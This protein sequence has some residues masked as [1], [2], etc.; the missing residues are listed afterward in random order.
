MKYRLQ[1]VKGYDARTPIFYTSGELSDYVLD[2]LT[3][4]LSI[5]RSVQYR[6][7]VYQAKADFFRIG[8]ITLRLDAS[9]LRWIPLVGWMQS[10]RD[11]ILTVTT[12]NDHILWKG[13]ATEVKTTPDAGAEW[14][15]TN[16]YN[17][18]DDVQI[19]GDD[20][21][22]RSAIPAQDIIDEVRDQLPIFPVVDA[23]TWF[24]VYRP[25]ENTSARD[26]LANMLAA[27]GRIL[28][29]DGN[30]DLEVRAIE[31][32]TA[33][34]LTSGLTITHEDLISVRI[35]DD[36]KYMY[37]TIRYE[38]FGVED[39]KIYQGELESY[40]YPGNFLFRYGRR[41]IDMDF[42]HLSV[43]NADFVAEQWQARLILPK[44]RALIEL[45]D[46]NRQ[47]L[48]LERIKLELDHVANVPIPIWG[49][50]AVTSI[51]INLDKDTIE[52]EAEEI[53]P[54]APALVTTFAPVFA[55]GMGDDQDWIEDSSSVGLQVPKASGL[56][57]PTYSASGLPA[58]ISFN[59]N[60]RLISG[61]PTS[62]GSGTITITAS[63]SQG[64]DTWTVDYAIVS[65][66]N[67][68][69]IALPASIYDEQSDY[70]VWLPVPGN[71]PQIDTVLT[72][73][74]NTTRY[75][76]SFRLY[77]SGRV[78][79][80]L[81]PTQTG[82]GGSGADFSSAVELNG[83]FDITVG[84]NDLSVN[85][86]GADVADIYDFT[87]SNS[88]E[89]TAF[90]N[91]VRALSGNQSATLVLRDYTTG[92]VVL[93]A[94]NFADDTGDDAD[95]T[96]NS[97][98]TNIQVPPASGTPIPTYTA[99]GLPA[100]ITFNTSSRVISGTPTAT[101]SG[102]IT[103][104]ATN[105]EGTDTWTVAY[106]TSVTLTAP[107]WTDDTGDDVDWTQNSAITDI[108]VPAASGNPTPTYAASGLPAGVTF[109]TG[110]R[111]I[112]GTPTGSGSGT[113]TITASNSE[114]SDTWTVDYTTSGALTAPNWADDT[115]DDQD[116]T[117]NS[118]ITSFTVPAATGNPAP[119]YSVAGLPNGITFNTGT[120]LLSGTPTAVG[121]GT[122]TVTA[123]NSQ[124]TDT[125][126]VD[127]ETV[128]AADD[129][130]LEFEFSSI[131]I[132]EGDT[133]TIRVRLTSQPTSTVTVTQS[134]SDA[135]ISV[136]PASRNFNTNNWGN[137]KSFTV[138]GIQDAD[139]DDDTATVTFTASGGSTAT[140]TVMVTIT[141]DDPP[142]TAPSWADDTGDAQTW[143]QNTAI[144]SFTVPA[145]SGSPTPTYAVVG[146]LPAGISFS[147]TT[148]L[149]SGTPTVSGNGTI[150]IRATN[151]QGSDDWTVGYTT[152]AQFTV[153]NF[154]DDTG[155]DVDWTRDTAI[156]S[157]TVPAATGNP[158]PTYV[159]SVLPAGISF[160]TSTR[161]ISGTPTSS[162]SGTITV[163]ATNSQ[164]SDTWTVDYA[165]AG[166]MQTIPLLSS[167]Y[168]EPNNTNTR[169]DIPSGQRPLIDAGLRDG[170]VNRW[171]ATVNVSEHGQLLLEFAAPEGETGSG[172]FDNLSTE[173]E[174]NGSV[175]ITVDP[176]SVTASL[177]G[178]DTV[179]PYQ[180]TPSNSAEAIQFNNDVRALA[181]VPDATLVLRD[182]TP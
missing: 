76:S 180:W 3:D 158:T 130:E 111:I 26:Y 66:G 135:D 36:K 62:A 65:L 94:P 10:D 114:G 56:P 77:S 105:S 61:T 107:N 144:T 149:I 14:R 139:S 59:Q 6:T 162:G 151:S 103:V 126:T 9:R 145:A 104:T 13:Y 45:P 118:A 140:G 101:G 50:F 127:Y 110:T 163:T 21:D 90:V 132:E 138:T 169:W 17:R 5:S 73:G 89:V 181:V 137:Y 54:L 78:R 136:T 18:L 33:T 167:W 172:T 30:G 80:N 40:Q 29:F 152:S 133:G 179:E 146:S 182:F 51:K 168:S 131:T 159:A 63:N 155:D 150:T 43:G 170:V 88:A 161:V 147:P 69:T 164:G 38:P 12:D 125:W 64:S 178:A 116:W 82:S 7:T 25:Q 124:G 113:I 119:T 47:V 98:I 128:A 75:I 177:A 22:T 67:D 72:E 134:E 120:R 74:G 41:E 166:N 112:S 53:P 142:A 165:I 175:T 84:G 86:D 85:F 173:F 52:L 34:F 48:L 96:R 141:D 83:G 129:P 81:N 39:A 46:P 70:I 71:R 19:A 171:L 102:T 93:S 174:T 91:A 20:D 27:Q 156:S 121:T 160:N 115:G 109:N 49:E 37:N 143:T 57:I 157:I 15:F 31:P 2:P 32:R 154:A 123:T 95:W 68:Q 58:G 16:L 28:L 148:R 122:I 35:L 100:G 24:D 106:T 79:V 11:H 60:Q 108:T 8:S 92:V 117:Q 4:I 97:A 99:S 23:S 55:D 153:P 87:P 42:S 44:K 176:F 1:I